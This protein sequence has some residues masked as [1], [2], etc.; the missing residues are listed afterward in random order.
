[1]SLLAIDSAADAAVAVAAVAL[2]AT[3]AGALAGSTLFYMRRFAAGSARVRRAALA[4][5]LTLAAWLLSGAAALAWVLAA[6]GGAAAALAAY[7]A[8]HIVPFAVLG[9]YTAWCRQVV[10]YARR[11]KIRAVSRGLALLREPAVK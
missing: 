4:F 6:Y 5:K 8:L 7:L 9:A 3:L 2:T 10:R 1:M 11:D